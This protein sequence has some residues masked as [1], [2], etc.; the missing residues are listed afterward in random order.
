MRATRAALYLLALLLGVLSHT[1]RTA[2][3]GPPQDD[4]PEATASNGAN[5]R[6]R[7]SL[8]LEEVEILRNSDANPGTSLLNN[9][10][11]AGA[12]SAVDSSAH[13]AIH[14][15]RA[16]L[17]ATHP[18]L[19]PSCQAMLHILE[20]TEEGRNALQVRPP[21]TSDSRGGEPSPQLPDTPHQRGS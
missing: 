5:H 4:Q 15:T 10:P 17:L 8:F 12:A 3:S 16:A 2:A 21:W 18:H 9:W 7:E 1:D 11:L 14:G 6:V 13:G 19:F 20:K